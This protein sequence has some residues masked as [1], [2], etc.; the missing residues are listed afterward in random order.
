M[1]LGLQYEELK[2]YSCVLDTVTRREE[3][4]ETI[5][6]DSMP[7]I[8][9]VVT[10]TATPLLRSCRTSD[11]SVTCEGEVSATVIYESEEVGRVFAIPVHVPFHCTAEA[12]EVTSECRMNVLPKL[13]GVE[14]KVMNPRKVLVQA[15]L[16]VHFLAFAEKQTRYSVGVEG[17]DGAPIQTRMESA[18]FQYVSQVTEKTFPFEENVSLPSGHRGMEQLLNC[19]VVPYCNETKIV[20]SKVVFKGGVKARLRFLSVEGELTA[21]EYDLP[22]SQVL[23]AGNSGEESIAMVSLSATDLQAT[24]VD[25]DSVSFQMELYACGI[26]LDR[27]EDRVLSDAYSTLY[28]CQCTEEREEGFQLAGCN[29]LVQSFRQAMDLE[30]PAAEV[31]DQSVALSEVI[32]DRTGGEGARCRLK[33]SACLRERD[34]RLTRVDQNCYVDVPLP[35]VSASRAVAEVKLLESACI[36]AAGGMEVRGSLLVSYAMIQRTSFRYL[37]GITLDESGLASAQQQPSAV[38]RMLR[39][40]ESLWDLGKEYFAAVEDILAVNQISDESEAG[41]RFLLIPRSR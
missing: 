17:G 24:M 29:T 26:L 5:V 35:A 9:T 40:G 34:G 14:V 32:C 19:D 4:Q 8:G 21:E 6:S 3:T 2:Y 37:S 38:L 28:P 7:D 33:V 20:G 22:V 25:Q 39:E 11:G 30:L 10:A 41:G 1:D 18:S 13:L 23:D 15:E 16:A 27:R 31:L 36:S 12:G